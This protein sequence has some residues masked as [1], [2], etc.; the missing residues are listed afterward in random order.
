MRSIDSTFKSEKNS[1]ENKPVFLYKVYNYDGSNND[2]LFAEW[3]TDITYAAET[4]T[5]FPI[6]HDFVSENI[7]GEVDSLK[8]YVGNASRAIQYYLEN[9]D[10]R[11]KKVRIRMV[12]ANQLADTDAYM[13]EIYYVDSYTAAQ[14]V[15][16]FT[17]TSKFDLLN[18]EIPKRRYSRNYCGWNFK[19]TE[20]AYAG[21]ETACNK[22]FGRCR[23]LENQERFGGFPSVPMRKVVGF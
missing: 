15:V 11:G 17:L 22:T 2:L 10:L 9:Y 16:E 1:S 3:D 12:W 6:K 23:E 18:I 14:D 8:I 4:Y 5:R 19:G 20:C 7:Q 21:A 13:D